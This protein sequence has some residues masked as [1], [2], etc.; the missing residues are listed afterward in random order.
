MKTL[1]LQLTILISSQL[2]H[3]QPPGPHLPSPIFSR[4]AIIHQPIIP[5]EISVIPAPP[6]PNQQSILAKI[7]SI[8]DL[9][10]VS[11]PMVGREISSTNFQLYDDPVTYSGFHK[12]YE[13][14]RGFTEYAALIPNEDVLYPGAAVQGKY[15]LGNQLV[16]IPLARTNGKITITTNFNNSSNVSRSKIV[17][18]VDLASV[19]D[20]KNTLLQEINPNGSVGGVNW[21]MVR[22]R[23]MNH[24][25]I[26]LGLNAKIGGFTAEASGSF[27]N[28]LETNTVVV[29]FYQIYYNVSFTPGDQWFFQESVS[30]SDFAH[31]ASA[32]NPPCY[33]SNVKYGR[34]LLIAFRSSTSVDSIEAA[35]KAGYNGGF[36]LNGSIQGA[37][38]NILENTEVS[39]LE[40]GSSGN[41]G[42]QLIKNLGMGSI[43]DLKNAL[44]PYLSSGA[45]VTLQNPGAPIFF[46]VN[47]IKNRAPAATAFTAQYE[48]VVDLRAPDESGEI[49]V[50]EYLTAPSEF[51]TNVWINQGDKV[52]VDASGKI[53]TGIAF[54]GGHGPTG[55]DDSHHAP[56]GFPAP[57]D[58]RNN[59]TYGLVGRIGPSPWTCIDN[60]TN[61][62]VEDLKEKRSWKGQGYLKF[63]ENDNILTNG[64]GCFYVNYYITRRPIEHLGKFGV[65]GTENKTYAPSY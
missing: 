17:N 65:G 60:G 59:C 46:T 57:Y 16:H 22:A 19:I 45:D 25:L 11:N 27:D 43:Q 28:S 5:K 29:K 15:L 10:V 52:M 1:F 8:P 34:L 24:A 64:H 47:Y 62:M 33:V 35:L 37:Y 42:I 7:R 44:D 14:T 49:Y 13:L 31:Y 53:F 61:D 40:V 51:N 26:Q 54:E 38:K 2:I 36:K 58:N 48:E 41:K 3:G 50:C 56:H 63:T 9:P 18:G 30:P 4:T 32:D 23:N 6:N 12:V 55:W 21:E 39:I 20:A